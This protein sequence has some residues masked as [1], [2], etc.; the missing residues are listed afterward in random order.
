[1]KA[2]KKSKPI[3]ISQ[4]LRLKVGIGYFFET[5]L[6]LKSNEY[7]FIGSFGKKEYSSDIDVAILRDFGNVDELKEK[8]ESFGFEVRLFHGFRELSFGFPFNRNIIQIDLMFSKNLE[9]SEFIYYS[10]NLLK[11]ESRYKGIYRNLLL[12]SKI[13]TESR[14]VIDENTCTQHILRL[15]EGL[16]FVTKSFIDAAGKK[17]NVSRIIQEKFITDDPK[18]FCKILN[19]EGSCLTFEQVFEQIKDRETYLEIKERFEKF[20]KQS[21]IEIP[22][23]IELWEQQK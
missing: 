19:L 9:W 2:I 4:Y 3:H 5:Y 21:K 11:D 6:Q 15:S 12:S 1:M 14:V 16:F 10:P 20:C 23:E 18:E 13:I 22:T 8:I 7:C 17:T